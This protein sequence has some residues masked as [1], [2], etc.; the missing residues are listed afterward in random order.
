M[1]E[2]RDKTPFSSAG[3]ITIDKSGEKS[4]T[5]VT[6]A[7]FD[8]L[9]SGETQLAEQQVEPL[10]TPEYY[11]APGESSL[12][13]EQDLIPEKPR[14]DIYLNASAYG[15][16]G[17]PATQALASIQTPRSNKSLIVH[18]D[19]IWEKNAMGII[20]ASSSKPF[21]KMPIVYERAYGGYD[22]QDPDPSHHR[23]DPYNPVGSGLFT[24]RAHTKDS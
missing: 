2:I 17:R 4:W 7:T 14:T 16:N 1:W 19:R 3:T 5:V 11:A 12:H 24:K 9:Q 20:S 6:K 8:I 18:G 13:Y 15:P 10:F 22:R 23:L 21:L